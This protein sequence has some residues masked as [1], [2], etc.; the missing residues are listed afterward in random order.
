MLISLAIRLSLKS[1]SDS[2]HQRHIYRFSSVLPHF[3]H[4]S[5]SS[6]SPFLPSTT[7]SLFHFQLKDIIC[8]QVTWLVITEVRSESFE[9]VTERRHYN[10]RHFAI[11]F[12]CPVW[13]RALS[14]RYA[15]ILLSGL[16][17][18][19]LIPSPPLSP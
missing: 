3:I 7:L 4:S 14:L 8:T 18:S 17:S 2:L 16:Y 11:I 9:L 1:I 19:P 6:S 10:A 13:Y 5:S 12:H 15:C